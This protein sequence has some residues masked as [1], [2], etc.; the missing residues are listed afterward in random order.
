MTTPI[1]WTLARWTC[2]IAALG[3]HFHFGV[4]LYQVLVA[5]AAT[6]AF[7]GLAVET[8]RRRFHPAR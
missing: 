3:S 2:P 6:C 7:L 4:G 5:N 8:R 1:L